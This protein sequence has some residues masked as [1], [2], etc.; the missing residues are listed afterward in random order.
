MA[1]RNLD[2]RYRNN[3]LPKT[4][5]NSILISRWVELET[6]TLRVMGLSLG[7]IARRLT[8]KGR[9]TQP[10]M[11]PVPAEVTFPANYSIT[12][13][14]CAKALKRALDREPRIEARTLVQVTIKRTEELFL[15]LQSDIRRGDTKAITAATRVLALQMNIV[16]PDS[17]E[18][19]LPATRKTPEKI[20][21]GVVGM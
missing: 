2:G 8:A 18:L 19:S 20:S 16:R 11:N 7:E 12:A 13:S 10:A 17:M 15:S 21:S 1:R 4:L 9:G 14:A 6:V 5:P 3:N